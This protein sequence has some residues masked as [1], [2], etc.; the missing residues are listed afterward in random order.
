MGNICRSPT[1]HGV[2]AKKVIDAGLAHAIEIDSAGTHAYHVGEPPDHRAQ[3]SALQRGYDLSDIAARKVEPVDCQRYDYLLVMDEENYS[4][5]LGLC[6]KDCSDKVQL[7][8]DY[9]EQAREREVPDPFYGGSRGFEYVLDLVEAASAG[10]L[11]L[12]RQRHNI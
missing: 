6:A 11:E 4:H 3:V 7:F 5:V 10:L 12:I 2:F 1:A 8:L 9:A